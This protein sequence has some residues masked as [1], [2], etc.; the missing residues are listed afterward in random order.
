MPEQFRDWFQPGLQLN[1]ELGERLA[2]WAA[3]SSPA[4]ATAGE[5]DTKS[6]GWLPIF[7]KLLALGGP[8]AAERILGK[9]GLDSANGITNSI[10]NK[11]IASGKKIK[12]GGSTFDDEFPPVVGP[13][14]AGAD[15]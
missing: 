10:G 13:P 6:N 14:D 11:L 8:D 4:Q 9:C 7:D 5:P 2:K 12:D 1:E 15:G 3:G